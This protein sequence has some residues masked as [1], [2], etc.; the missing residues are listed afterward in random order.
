M[1]IAHCAMQLNHHTRVTR[2]MCYTCNILQ[3]LPGIVLLP[4]GG[5]VLYTACILDVSWRLLLGNFP[6]VISCQEAAIA[7]S[8]AAAPPATSWPGPPARGADNIFL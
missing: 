6:L 2:V 4:P 3:S 5:W 1:L 7:R 8:G